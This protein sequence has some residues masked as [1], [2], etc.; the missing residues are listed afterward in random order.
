MPEDTPSHGY[1]SREIPRGTWQEFSKIEEEFLEAKDA[2]EQGVSIMLLTELS[3]LYGAIEGYLAKHHP[4]IS[5]EDLKLMHDRT[6]A[7]FELGHRVPR[8]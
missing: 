1:H 3:D 2:Y 5:M 6:S 4:D 7:S 8:K